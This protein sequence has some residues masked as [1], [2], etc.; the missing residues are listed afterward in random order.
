MRTLLL[1]LFTIV[2]A[3]I[4][5]G[6]S[7]ETA[8]R[9]IIKDGYVMRTIQQDAELKDWITGAM[10]ENARNAQRADAAQASESKVR[11]ELTKAKQDNSLVQDQIILLKKTADAAVAH[12]AE[13]TKENKTLK[14]WLACIGSVVALLLCLWLRVPDLSPPWGV[15]VSFGS[16]V[17]VFLLILFL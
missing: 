6:Q 17:I 2:F 11:A 1:F 4:S 15:V 10:A 16:P 5:F 7:S 3:A 12:D 9:P 8:H 13:T 14:L